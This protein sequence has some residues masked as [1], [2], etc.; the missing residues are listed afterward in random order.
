MK[1]ADSRRSGT[2]V[3]RPRGALVALFVG[4]VVVLAACAPLPAENRPRAIDRDKV[5]DLFAAPTTTSPHGTEQ[6]AVCFV[7]QT[8]GSETSESACIAARFTDISPRTLFDALAAGP[9]DE[10]KK[11]GLTSL[12]PGDT[13][14]LGAEP[15]QDD[16]NVLVIDLSSEI[17]SLSSPNN[18]IAYRQIVETLTNDINDLGADAIRVRVD[19]KATKI[20]TD[21][22]QLATADPSDF[23]AD[24]SGPRSFGKGG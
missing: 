8:T 24:S 13:E 16:P 2:R 10:L 5:P 9:D 20:P 3:T 21:K 11:E 14:L 1:I 18:I 12:V 6:G 4:V 19:G 23:T 17:N 22:G 15:A 7:L